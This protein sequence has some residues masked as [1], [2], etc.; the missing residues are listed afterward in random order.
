MM[1]MLFLGLPIWQH[2]DWPGEFLAPDTSPEQA[3]AA[4]ATVFNSVEGNTTFYGIPRPATVDRWAANTPPGFRFCFKFP[5]AIS[6]Q[7][8]LIPGGD[9]T[10]SFLDAM[11]PLAERLGPLFLQL[12]PSF[13]PERLGE[14]AAYLESLP[15]RFVY[16]VEARHRGFFTKGEAE[17]QLNRLLHGLSMDRVILDSR[18]LHQILG[19]DP[20]L[21]EVRHRKPRLPVHAVALANNPMVRFIGHPQLAANEDYL[22]PWIAKLG[23]WLA[24]GRQPYFFLHTPS[25][26]DAPALA[27]HFHG[28]LA[29]DLGVPGP[30]AWPI[31]AQQPAQLGLF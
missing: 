30:T 12:P 15:Q 1:Q 5:R 11:A 7:G 3:L 25:N 13:G 29:T 21:R 26:R 31:E 8:P 22:Q 2:P 27:R 4:Y 9:T 19:D 18:A 10:R 14:L 28:R 6:H 17:K 23:E 24:E 16:A 20:L